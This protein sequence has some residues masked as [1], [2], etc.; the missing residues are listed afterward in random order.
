MTLRERIKDLCKKNEISVNKLEIDL[1]FG[2]GYVSKLDKSI[3]NSEKLQKIADYLDVSLDYLMTGNEPDYSSE[4]AH[5]VARIRNDAELSK[6]LLKYFELSNIKKKH[7]IE[8]INLLS[9]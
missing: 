9:E 6:A 2:K 1:K 4:S 7:V 8:T 5:L 3:P